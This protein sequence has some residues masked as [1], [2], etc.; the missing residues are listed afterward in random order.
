MHPPRE[1]D[2]PFSELAKLADK[3]LRDD[4][5]A[6][7]FFKFTCE[8]CGARNTFSDPNVLYKQGRCGD[9]GHITPIRFGGFMLE[10]TRGVSRE[11]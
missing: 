3:T 1:G 4:P 8:A 10:T 9:C 5:Y 11:D 7:L 6:L 2:L